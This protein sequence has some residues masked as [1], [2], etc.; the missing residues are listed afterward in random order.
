MVFYRWCNLRI[1]EV[2]FVVNTPGIYFGR[3]YDMYMNSEGIIF[4]KGERRLYRENPVKYR[5]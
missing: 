2:F 5:V 3:I 1:L 4:V